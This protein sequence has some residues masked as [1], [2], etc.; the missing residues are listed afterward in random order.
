MIFSS[1]FNREGSCQD[2]AKLIT[3][4]NTGRIALTGQ[5]FANEMLGSLGITAFL[6]KK[7]EHKTILINSAAQKMVHAF[8]GD[9]NFIQMSFI[10]K[11]RGMASDFVSIVSSE[12]LCP[13]PHCLMSDDDAAVSQLVFHHATAER[14][15]VIKRGVAIGHDG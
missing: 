6:H 5:E 3:H 11:T 2:G 12:L 13:F 1:F 10:T 8:D 4:Y 9:N 7:V 14:K 15:A